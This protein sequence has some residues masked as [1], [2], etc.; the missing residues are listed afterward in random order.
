MRARTS[1]SPCCCSDASSCSLALARRCSLAHLAYVLGALN[2]SAWRRSDAISRAS[3]ALCCCRNPVCEVGAPRRGAGQGA[4]RRTAARCGGSSAAARARAGGALAAAHARWRVAARAA[5]HRA[6]PACQDTH[7]AAL[8]EPARQ[9]DEQEQREEGRGQLHGGQRPRRGARTGRGRRIC[10]SLAGPVNAPAV[11]LAAITPVLPR[12]HCGQGSAIRGPRG[13]AGDANEL[14]RPLGLGAAARRRGRWG[15]RRAAAHSTPPAALPLAGRGEPRT[16]PR[17]GPRGAPGEGTSC[18]R[19]GQ[20][21]TQ[22]AGGTWWWGGRGPRPS[23]R[24]ARGGCVRSG[25]SGGG[26]GNWGGAGRRAPRRRASAHR[27]MHAL[28]RRWRG[29]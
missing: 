24:T 15:T 21:Y 22:T 29:A 13:R 26:G 16:V 6:R 3:R 7:L 8:D 10:G 4:R 20:I 14:G 19:Q 11:A 2:V 5:T 23:W 28:A 9:V 1:L 12:P 17:A 18:L 25:S 27:H